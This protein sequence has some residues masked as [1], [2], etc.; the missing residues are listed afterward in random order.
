MSIPFTQLNIS[1]VTQ[2]KLQS[3]D[4][5]SKMQ[6]AQG[7]GC[8][9]DEEAL[10]VLMLLSQDLDL[11]VSAL[12]QSSF[13][14][15]D[16]MRLS[17]ALTR[18][19]HGKIL[20]FVVQ[21]L[22]AYDR[23]DEYIFQSANL[24][25]RT[26]KLIAQ[27]VG[28]D[29]CQHIAHT[30]Q[31]F[32]LYPVVYWSLKANSNCTAVILE[33]LEATLKQQ[34]CFVEAPKKSV[35]VQTR[36]KLP[37]DNI[38]MEVMAAVQSKP[39]PALEKALTSQLFLSAPMTGTAGMEVE[40]FEFSFEEE[41]TFD[42]DASLV[43]DSETEATEE[44][45]MSLEKRIR[46]MPVGKR[47]KLAYKGNK[48]ARGILIR[49][50]NK[51]VSVA[52]LKSGKVNAGEAAV[53]AANRNLSDEVIRTICATK[54]YM[55]KQNVRMALVGNPK[56]PTKVAMGIL[57][58]LG[59]KDLQALAKNRSVSTNISKAALKRFKTEFQR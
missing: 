41:D 15:W 4:L 5:T 29:A 45:N 34:Q 14:M 2:E 54:E 27:R 11:V 52:V 16:E 40:A 17:N 35:V 8:T 9:S 56:T 50:T 26:A 3:S 6:L 7:Q 43:Q 57:M 25:E 1:P 24:N 31:T 21:F 51:S 20:E 28:A 38:L 44:E 23:I 12:A 58:T 32:L 18:Q 19:T 33:R 59:K 42:F 55:R 47:I 53:Y 37:I 39:S 49:D 30:R 22:P 48:E 36:P 13:K 46:E 10:A